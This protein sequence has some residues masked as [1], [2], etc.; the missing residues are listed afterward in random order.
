[1]STVFYRWGAGR[2]EARVKFDGTHI[3]VFDFKR[4][5]MLDNNLG[6]GKDFDLTVFENG[7]ELKDD[8][9][10]I[11][12]SSTLVVRRR[13]AIMKGRGTAQNYI[14]GTDASMSLTGEHRI[15]A[16]A[17]QAMKDRMMNRGAMGSGGTYGSM[18]KRF[19]GKEEKKEAAPKVTTGNADE[20]ARIQAMLQQQTDTWEEMQEDMSSL[21]RFNTG[22]NRR[23][24]GRPGGGAG[25]GGGPPGKFDFSVAPDK[26]PPLGYICY[27]CGQKGHWIQNCPS[28]DDPAAQDR[29]R[30]VRVTGIPRSFLKT[31]ETPTTGE[32]S[33]GGA[34]LTADGGFVRAVPDARAWEKQ[35]AVKTLANDDAEDKGAMDPELVCPLCKKLLND[36]TRTPCCQ[37]AY[38]EDCITSHLM[39]HDFVCPSCESKIASLDKLEPDEDLRERAKAYREGEK[40]KSEEEEKN[41]E[42]TPVG[43]QDV[44]GKN[45][46]S[47]PLPDMNAMTDHLQAML[48][49]LRNPLVPPAAKTQVRQ[50]VKMTNHLLLQMQML[51]AQ[52]MLGAMAGMGGMGMG[53]GMPMIGNAMAN[54]MAMMGMQGNIGMQGNMGNMGPGMNMG[55]GNMGPGN[56]GGNMGPGPMGPGH[57]NMGG[58]GRGGFRGGMRGRGFARGGGMGRVNSG[59]RPAEDAAGGMEKMQRVA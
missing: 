19:D 9:K 13:P 3:S 59:K 55:P 12:R 42:D 2:D 21:P 25:G 44:S 8:D 33:S 26:E 4:Q 49:T 6:N 32:G 46:Y 7:E 41:G 18:S 53:M 30:F 16:H 43:E 15:E 20:D 34:M 27:R 5:I 58:R 22:A 50:H 48:A 57:M 39:E 52:G 14:V 45:P 10:Q 40:G 56:M 23:P 28:N 1:M 37:T 35:A 17:R 51:A 36:A 31:V 11:A 38:C 24:L 29:K 47:G 54:P